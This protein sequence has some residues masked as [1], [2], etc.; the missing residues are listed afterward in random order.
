MENFEK[1]TF[2]IAIFYMDSLG[3]R[4]KMIQVEYFWKGIKFLTSI[5][6]MTLKI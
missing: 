5:K 6:H 2:E 4:E 3:R 1:L